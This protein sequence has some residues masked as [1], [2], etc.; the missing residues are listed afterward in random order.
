MT[1]G[2]AQTEQGTAIYAQREAGGPWLRLDRPSL[3]RVALGL[4]SVSDVIALFRQLEAHPERLVGGPVRGA[5]AVR[6]RPFDWWDGPLRDRA[7]ADRAEREAKAAA[8]K[9]NA[10]A[11]RS[12]TRTQHKST[13][14][15]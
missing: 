14:A 3:L 11:R 2:Y 4:S 1:P 9:Q 7:R 13:E 8:R 5:V 10:R 15:K 6:V 12:R